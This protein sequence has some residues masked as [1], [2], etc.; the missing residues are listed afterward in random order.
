MKD[1][2]IDPKLATQ[3]RDDFA[4][5]P[6]RKDLENATS[7]EER[8][9]IFGRYLT[10]DV[11]TAINTEF[12]KA[13]ASNQKSALID[14]MK[15][16]TNPAQQ[17]S[18]G[19]KT[20][21][22][23]INELEK[24]GA[25]GSRPD[26][27]LEDLMADKL[28]I[29]IHP[30]EVAEITKRTQKLDTLFKQTDEIGL[31]S[32]EYFKEL[33]SVNNYIDSLS[34]SPLWSVMVTNVRRGNMLFNTSSP[35]VNF[36][37]N[38][39]MGSEQAAARRIAQWQF[40]GSS[41]D[42]AMKYVQKVNRVYWQTGYDISRMES[43]QAMQPMIKGEQ[44]AT[45]QG[46]GVV[47]AFARWQQ[48]IVFSK[49]MN[50]TPFASLA[51]ADSMNLMAGRVALAENPSLV[52]DALKTRSREIFTDAM[53]IEPITN[54]GKIVKT[55]G[56]EDA[57]QST[58]NNKG[59]YAGFAL[60]MRDAVNKLIPGAKAG[61]FLFPFMKTTADVV[62]FN[63]DAAGIGFPRGIYKFIEA[64]RAA[65]LGNTDMAAKAMQEGWK[66][67]T[68]A[69]LGMLGAFAVASMIN[70]DDFVSQYDVM[71]ANESQL[72]A[73]KNAP[74][75][76]IKMGDIYVSL[77]YFGPW[78]ASIVGMMYAK[79]YGN[80]LPEMA[81]KYIQ[82]AGSQVTQIPGVKPFADT[83]KSALDIL[84][85]KTT[86]DKAAQGAGAGAISSIASIVIPG[87]LGQLARA[88]DPYQRFTGK[89]MMGDIQST[90]PGW[91]EQLP[92]KVNE[93]TGDLASSESMVSTLLFGRRVT[94]GNKSPLI[95]EVQRLA[96]VNTPMSTSLIENASSRMKNLKTQIS[97]AD[98]TQALQDYGKEFG[99]KATKIITK[100]YYQ[101]MTDEKKQDTL[102]TIRG[103]AL[104]KTLRKYHYKASKK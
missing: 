5:G 36:L 67:I 76:S 21:I 91:R 32:D 29:N 42:L 14:W 7:T 84:N 57:L 9:A 56:V 60:G 92:P 85:K 49:L 6:L 64:K 89:D 44:I 102:N 17:Q 19:Y 59:A 20:A 87:F 75:N 48:D 13:L 101:K 77:D 24:M 26:G 33:K 73:I 40:H 55:Q 72:A 34:P 45:A 97:Q 104:D 50:D 11:A 15:K 65:N 61:D 54:A 81:W 22:D 100:P 35:V 37:S 103:D 63:I 51:R 79:K 83:V 98:F 38:V 94:T 69:G 46:P 62:E 88:T 99:D 86:W 43:M 41:G 47:R 71:S 58:W 95:T 30:D 70:P 10:K 23:K 2:C 93:F 39:A 53:Q 74:A 16:T 66:H 90:V 12:E 28:G 4:N 80:T 78:A 31:P 3:I 25:L 96:N 18:K 8:H 27:F 68:D 52:G 1:F 82:G